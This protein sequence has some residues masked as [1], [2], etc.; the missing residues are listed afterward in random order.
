MKLSQAKIR[1]IIQ[2]EVNRSILLRMIREQEEDDRQSEDMEDEA[3][4]EQASLEEI[5]SA[6]SAAGLPVC[7]II[8]MSSDSGT[9]PSYVGDGN[10]V[11]MSA[12]DIGEEFV[13][14]LKEY[15]SEKNE[16]PS[17]IFAAIINDS[18]GN[19]EISRKI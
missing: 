6:Y 8:D 10:D 18:T 19:L 14:H 12:E 4:P 9:Y 11:V 1:K 2:E 5:Q 16:L 13:A 7:L 15:F 3:A 17:G